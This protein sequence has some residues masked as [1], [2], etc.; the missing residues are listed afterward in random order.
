LRTRLHSALV[1]L[2]LQ[3][4]ADTVADSHITEENGILR[5]VIPEDTL[6]DAS[7]IQKAL[8]ALGMR[9]MRV[10]VAT[11]APQS[12]RLETPQRKAEGED[13]ATERALSHPGVKAFRDKFP[14][15][16]V[17][18]VRNLKE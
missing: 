17:R 2:G 13:E 14:D 7:D 3:F 6:L 18:T 15:A 4:S 10:S 8:Q 1:D 12:A 9:P 16:H 5:F 11:G